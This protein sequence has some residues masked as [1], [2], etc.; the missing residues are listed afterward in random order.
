MSALGGGFNWSAA[1]E[2]GSG[3]FSLMALAV[4]RFITS[5]NFVRQIAGLVLLKARQH[6][7][8]P[9]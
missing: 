1:T 8:H 9:E 5:L 4:L 2:K 7:R 3:M 6:H